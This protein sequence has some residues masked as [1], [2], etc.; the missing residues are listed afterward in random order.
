MVQ[1]RHKSTGKVLLKAKNDSI[2][3]CTLSGHDLTGADFSDQD[4]SGCKFTGCNL[5]DADFSGATLNLCKI[6]NS[7]LK[8]A[9]FSNSNLVNADLSDNVFDVADFTCCIAEGTLFRHS[10]MSNQLVMVLDQ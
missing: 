3:G 2:R 1:I 7:V 6:D 9:D 5:N 10:K 4:L 8:R